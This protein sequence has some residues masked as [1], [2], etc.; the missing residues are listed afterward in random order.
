[1]HTDSRSHDPTRDRVIDQF[2]DDV[3]R[4]RPEN[5]TN[6]RELDDPVVEGRRTVQSLSWNLA[7]DSRARR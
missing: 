6:L 3:V 2:R 5:T 7:D 4:P 1:M